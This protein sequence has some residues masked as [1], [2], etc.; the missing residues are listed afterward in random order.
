MILG[1]DGE[2]ILLISSILVN[3]SFGFF[4]KLEL[5]KEIFERKTMCITAIGFGSSEAILYGSNIELFSNDYI[6]TNVVTFQ[7][8]CKMIG[9][10]R[11]SPSL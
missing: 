8:A 10:A 4:Y 6:I 1:F 7:R 2:S 3:L 9:Q 11:E 5:K